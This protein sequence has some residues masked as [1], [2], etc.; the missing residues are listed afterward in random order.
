MRPYCS[1]RSTPARYPCDRAS[2]RPNGALAITPLGLTTAAEALA[3]AAADHT[4]TGRAPASEVAM[5]PTD[6][7][8]EDVIR[9]VRAIAKA[10]RTTPAQ[11]QVLRERQGLPTFLSGRTLCT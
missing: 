5:N 8:V 11:I 10:L 2:K 9:G 3:M 4:T 1:D 7:N 6:H